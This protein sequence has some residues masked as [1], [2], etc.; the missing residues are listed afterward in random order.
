MTSE[1]RPTRAEVESAF[2]TIIRWAGDNPSRDGL[3]ETPSRVAR[4][5]DLARTVDAYE[6]V[7]G[8]EP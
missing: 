2:K 5:F 7:L 8:G 3:K 1:K 4:A 6:S